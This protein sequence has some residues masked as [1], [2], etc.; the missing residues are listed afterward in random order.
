[1]DSK[2]KGLHF[3]IETYKYLFVILQMQW[4]LQT[5]NARLLVLMFFI[6]AAKE[7]FP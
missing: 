1:M 2:D 3:F 5:L 7:D 6:P 4:T